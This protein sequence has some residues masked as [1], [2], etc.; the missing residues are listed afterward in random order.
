M[1]YLLLLLSL[2]ALLSCSK[3]DNSAL[4][5]LNTS[6][7]NVV[8]EI[9]QDS[10]LPMLAIDKATSAPTLQTMDAVNFQ[11]KISTLAN[12]IFTCQLNKTLNGPYSS[13]YAEYSAAGIGCPLNYKWRFDA[14]YDNA[15]NIYVS[16][17]NVK[18]TYIEPSLSNI[19]SIIKMD[20][21]EEKTFEN[22]GNYSY[23]LKGAG[24]IE[25]E[26]YGTIS[27]QTI[28][29]FQASSKTE[30]I[31]RTVKY[32]DFQVVFTTATDLNSYSKKYFMNN[33]EISKQEM[34]EHFALGLN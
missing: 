2:F 27:V 9:N 4:P 24:F 17:L 3:N 15:T 20:Y 8:K 21:T 31:V 33:I 23:S 29:T 6:Q 22:G 16:K 7:M 19:T 18:Q 25:S 12:K 32:P 5:P 1:K 26:K 11:E 30:T 14:T 13:P 28:G 10:Q 34:Q